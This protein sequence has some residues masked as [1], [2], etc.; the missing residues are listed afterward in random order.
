MPRVN[1]HN[2][3]NKKTKDDLDFNK[4]FEQI[5]KDSTAAFQL[6]QRQLERTNNVEK[7]TQDELTKYRSH[8]Y[9]EMDKINKRQNQLDVD[10]F[11]CI[12]CFKRRK[13]VVY[14]GCHHFLICDLCEMKMK[15]KKCSNCHNEYSKIFKV[16]L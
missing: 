4:R 7:M 5:K 9:S 13:N 14:G 8:I 3:E 16:N 15:I 12:I 2:Y 10:K 1:V 11:N 6:L